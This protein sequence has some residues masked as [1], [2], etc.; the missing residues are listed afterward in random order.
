MKNVAIFGA[1]SAIAQ[2]T[3]KLL[4]KEKLS[5][6]LLDQDETKLTIVAND[7]KVR[8]AG[9][10]HTI[11][12]DLSHTET[13]STLWSQITSFGNPDTVLIAYGTLGN[14]KKSQADF[15]ITQKELQTNFVSVVSLLT[16]I[17]ND[18]EQ[19]KSGTIAVISSVAGDR[20]RQSNYVYSSAKG[21]L[22]I[23]LSGL[24]NRLTPHNVSVI[25]IKPGFIDTPMTTSF[26][27]GLLWAKPETIAPGIVSAIKHKKSTVYLP[28]FWR[29]IML[30]IR[31]IPEGIFK[32]MKL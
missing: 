28:W 7:L 18:F 16:L 21:A 14:Q 23:F 22:T 30:I 29:Y 20:G 6:V 32:Q 17:A 12:A 2:A 13:H 24:R 19:Q 27:K 31:L 10:V 4:V 3:A 11:T 1:A 15:A 25:T 9:A 5:F 26:K 8:G